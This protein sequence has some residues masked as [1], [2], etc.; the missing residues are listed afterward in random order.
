MNRRLKQFIYGTAFFIFL[1]IIVSGF[2]FAFLK[3]APSCFDN[4][5]NQNEE[6]IDCG[7]ICGNSCIPPDIKEIEIT[8][9]KIFRLD[10]GR[11][12]LFAEIKNPNSNFAAKSFNYV[13]NAYDSNNQVV[14][15]ASGDLFLYGGETGYILVPNLEVGSSSPS[16][17]EVILDK[18]EWVKNDDFKK[19]EISIQD[20]S[21]ISFSS[22]NNQ[23]KVGDSLTNKS[24]SQFS[25]VK[26]IAIFYN[27]SGRLVGASETELT[28]VALNT[29]QP[30]FISHPFL[31]EINPASTRFFIRAK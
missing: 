15:N 21:D 22:D 8:Q 10:N 18:V 11:V 16:R 9:Q 2:Y 31:S 7:G 28:D 14:E 6:G 3:P 1:A 23:I 26:I 4:I 25:G 19:P 12:S 27:S 29:D 20:I 24:I 5:K 13:F 30:F 17:P